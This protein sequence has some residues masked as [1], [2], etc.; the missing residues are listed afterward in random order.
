[1]PITSCV[2]ARTH[3]AEPVVQFEARRGGCTVAEV[4]DER[5]FGVAQ[6]G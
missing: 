4:D 3:E 6:C 2:R 5:V 1:M